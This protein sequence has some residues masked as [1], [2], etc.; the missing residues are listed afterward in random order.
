MVLMTERLCE[1]D[2]KLT[3]VATAT[4]KGVSY[5]YYRRTIVK[6]ECRNLY[7]NHY[8][9]FV[10]IPGFY[11]S[12][13]KE[14]PEEWGELDDS[15]RGN[16]S[17]G[18]IPDK[19]DY[20]LFE[21]HFPGFHYVIEK[22]LKHYCFGYEKLFDTVKIWLKHPEIEI[23]LDKGFAQIAFNKNF[24]RL[25]KKTRKNYVS[26]LKQCEGISPT[27]D[28]L[29]KLKKGISIERYMIFHSP[30]FW[31]INARKYNAKP[32]TINY[33][34]NKKLT[35]RE[36]KD[37]LDM[38]QTAGHDISDPYWEFPN[39]FQKNH[40]K[41]IE[42]TTAIKMLKNKK[43]LEPWEKK[44]SKAVKKFTQVSKFKDMKVYVP[45]EIDLFTKQAEAL[46]QCL[47]TARYYEDVAKRKKILVFIE[48]KG[49]PNATAEILI[50]KKKFTLNQFYGDERKADYKAS[51]EAQ[52]ALTKWCRETNIKLA[53]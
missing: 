21:K 12:W 38:A 9:K 34:M 26:L 29:A 51:E 39:N 13:G 47:I 46:H 44:Y 11:Y 36:Y 45:Q 28:M 18:H 43:L 15:V 17:D 27:M 2:G 32:E 48:K 40:Q 14:E 10:H 4:R 24:W 25:T 35:A 1:I 31:D 16:L 37:Y 52:K 30:E 33:I 42:E 3:I 7:Q 41:V 49:I 50:S 19:K 5:D 20:D 53:S 23:L 22:S 8:G 6:K